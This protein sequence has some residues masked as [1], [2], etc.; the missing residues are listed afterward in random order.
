MY[1]LVYI[2]ES[3]TNDVLTKPT[4]RDSSAMHFNSTTNWGKF[5]VDYESNHINNKK[6]KKILRKNLIQQQNYQKT[7][8]WDRA[9]Q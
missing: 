4:A 7:V 6:I 2:P 3:I 5:K 1:S 9:Y 8:R